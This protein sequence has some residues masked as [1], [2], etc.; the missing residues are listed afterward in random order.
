MKHIKFNF[1]K[2]KQSS[3][4]QS[5]SVSP[6][7]ENSDGISMKMETPMGALEKELPSDFNLNLD[8]K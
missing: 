8:G 7:S 4:S 6:D 2:N 5:S 3:N 1:E